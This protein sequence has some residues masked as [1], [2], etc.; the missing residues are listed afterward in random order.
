MGSNTSK[1][2]KITEAIAWTEI[3]KP[4]FFLTIQDK[5]KDIIELDDRLGEE[6][7]GETLLKRTAECML[8]IM[9]EIEPSLQRSL[10]TAS[11]LIVRAKHWNFIGWI[12][13]TAFSIG[14]FT[15]L[16]IP[17]LVDKAQWLAVGGTLSSM[18]MFISDYLLKVSDGETKISAID[19]RNRLIDLRYEFKEGRNE[20]QLR[21]EYLDD[22]EKLE[23]AISRMNNACREV[24]KISGLIDS[25][26]LR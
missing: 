24:N 2:T 22:K 16:N 13:T 12:A 5:F 9:S 1:R 17:Y 8:V 21:M 23:Q 26:N 11:R 14:T 25:L 18:A 7:I 6:D 4:E 19:A 10:I 20:L 15:A 3:N